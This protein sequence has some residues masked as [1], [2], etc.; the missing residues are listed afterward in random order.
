MGVAI[1]SFMLAVEIAGSVAALAL[2]WSLFTRLRT[3]PRKRG[4]F[5]RLPLLL[6]AVVFVISIIIVGQLGILPMSQYKGTSYL[7]TSAT[8][9]DIL[10]FNVYE[11]D[12]VY[13]E[14]VELTLSMYLLPDESIS[15]I[16]EFYLLDGLVETV[17]VNLTSLSV[18]ETITEERT[19]ILAP[20]SY[21]VHVNNTFYDHGILDDTAL[22]WIEIRLSQPVKSSFTPEIVTWSS[23]QFGLNIGCFFFI[24]G[25]FCIGGSK[26]RYTSEEPHEEPQTDFGEGGPEYGKGC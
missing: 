20:G 26:P 23:L 5:Q 3:Q 18:E 12:I 1:E 15:N 10:R 22:H 13:S 17:Y 19:L 4:V 14:N 25:G 11:P 21:V 2:I 16:I 7:S 8:S 9:G 6:P 24:L